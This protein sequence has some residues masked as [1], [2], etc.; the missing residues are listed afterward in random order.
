M[1]RTTYTDADKARAYVVFVANDRIM[2]RT[3]RDAGLPESTLRAWIAEWDKNGPPETEE[4]AAAAQ[5]FTDEAKEVRG[6]AVGVIRQKLELLKL[7]PKEVK[8]AEVTTLI[9]V[10]TDKIQRSEGL[11]TGK[12]VDHFHHLPE[13]E[14]LRALMG[15]YI[16]GSISAATRRAE[17]I[18]DAEFTE[19]AELPAGE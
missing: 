9:G 7:N 18:V 10:L 13:P 2:K 6:M 11:N 8:I 1:A 4:V 3:A 17:E 12:R 5:S 15:E 14:E 16:D 19:Q